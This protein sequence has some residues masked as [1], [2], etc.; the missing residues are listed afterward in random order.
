QRQLGLQWLSAPGAQASEPLPAAPMPATPPDDIALAS[1]RDVVQLGYYRGIL[2]RLAE[3]ESA[4]PS[5]K[6]FCAQMRELARAFEFEEIARR[7]AAA[8]H[9]E[10]TS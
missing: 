6:A 3:I 1:L 9:K 10:K 5:A 8:A 7:L 2:N 4:Q